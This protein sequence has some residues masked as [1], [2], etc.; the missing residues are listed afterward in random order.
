MDSVGFCGF[1]RKFFGAE[2]NGKFHDE[3]CKVQGFGMLQRPFGKNEHPGRQKQRRR[4]S[5][6]AAK[7]VFLTKNRINI[8]FDFFAKINL[9]IKKNAIHLQFE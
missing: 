8:F 6:S 2:Q 7:I 5:S 1:A 9:L 3:S 4:K